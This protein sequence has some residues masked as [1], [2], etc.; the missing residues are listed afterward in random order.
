L[1]P[2]HPLPSSVRPGEGE[3]DVP[4]RAPLALLRD[5]LREGRFDRLEDLVGLLGPRELGGLLVDAEA[6]VSVERIDWLMAHGADPDAPADGADGDTA[7][8]TLLAK[9]PEQAEAIRALLR[10][11]VSPAGAGGLA[12]FLSACARG[13]QGARGLEQL[14]LELLDRGADPFASAAG[15]DPALSL[16]VRLGWLRLLEELAAAGVDL[17]ARDGRGMTALH[18]A[19]ALGREGALRALVRLGANPEVRAADG[20]TPLGVA[21]AAGRRDLA[22][23]LDWRGWRLP[24][25]PL[26]PEDLPA[27]AVA[28]DAEAVRKLLDLGFAVDTTD[29][30][31][32]SALLRAAGGGH[33]EVV[34]L[35]LG[36]SA[37]PQLAAHSGATPLS[38]A[39]SMGHG[40]I[41]ERLLAAGAALEQRLPGDVTVLMLAA[42][43]GLPEL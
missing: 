29:A 4:D 2:E 38:A 9:G 34:E 10:H 23:W 28:G 5:G 31:G 8:F 41:V 36:R 3:A 15:S 17:D 1:D 32:C 39:V 7:M 11:N 43:L 35:L 26:Q 14:A 21:L 19:A 16:A 24:R 18:L 6:P 30:Q 20:Q 42:A 12:R 37:D 22:G 40:E 33:L 25:R 13:D 27:A